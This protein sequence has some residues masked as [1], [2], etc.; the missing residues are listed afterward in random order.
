MH[1]SQPRRAD[2]PDPRRLQDSS[3]AAFR[4]LVLDRTAKALAALILAGIAA[5]HLSSPVKA[6][7]LAV[8]F[9]LA[10]FTLLTPLLARRIKSAALA[11][12]P[13]ATTLMLL[14]LGA[15]WKHGGLRAPVTA[16]LPM[17]PILGFFFGGRRLGGLLLGASLALTAGLYALGLHGLVEQVPGDLTEDRNKAVVLAIAAVAG[18]VIGAIY[19]RCRRIAAANLVEASRLVSLGVMAG[20]IAH[21]INN[22][23]T[24]IAGFSDRLLRLA[25]QRELEPEAV[26]ALAE[27][28]VATTKRIAEIIAGLRAYSRDDAREPL[29]PASLSRIV[30]DALV[31]CRERFRGANVDLR[32]EPVPAESMIMARPVQIT[33]VLLNLLSNAFDAVEHA[34]ERWVQVEVMASA[35]GY[36]LSVADSGPGVPPELRER[37]FVPFF[38]TKEVGKG[39]GLGLSLSASIMSEHGGEVALAADLKCTTFVLRFPAVEADAPVAV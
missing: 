22:P 7:Q 26:G 13:L 35:G 11:A 17:L 5:R 14:I 24:I 6:P 9:A 37:I 19:E 38:T 36:T 23:L 18:Y 10:A 31:L 32:V 33:Q 39:T 28:L 3:E 12:L 4:R 25:R 21:E 8:G 16:V 27:R 20:G 15:G 30:E 29:R 1:L 2:A 34:G